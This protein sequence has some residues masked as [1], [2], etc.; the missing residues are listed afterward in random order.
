MQNDTFTLFDSI[1]ECYLKTYSFNLFLERKKLY[2]KS[3]QTRLKAT[4]DKKT[5]IK[6]GNNSGVLKI[7]I[8]IPPKTV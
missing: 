4:L 3:P 1:C 6:D 8:D 2:A 7:G 5:N